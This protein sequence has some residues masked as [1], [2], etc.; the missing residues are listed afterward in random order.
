MPFVPFTDGAKMCFDFTISGVEVS[1]CLHFKGNISPTPA[2][3]D[4]LANEG[5]VR[6]AA[7]VLP[8]QTTA[9]LFKGTTVYDLNTANSPV[10]QDYYVTPVAGSSA[11][12]TS[13]LNVAFVLSYLTGNRGRSYRG[14]SYIPGL[15]ETVADDQNWQAQTVI[16]V[17]NGVGTM[18]NAI[19][20]NS[21]FE[22]VVASRVQNGQLLQ[23]GVM[24]PVLAL[25]GKSD[26][27]TR[28]KRLQGT[29]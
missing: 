5:K 11:T 1:I 24:T 15:S 17:T 12:P 7:N 14:R 18:I 27:G 20:N 22:F 21:P 6:W 8:L 4:T 23:Q 13:P 10:Y 3:Y 19:E 16:D 28:R 25:V 29:F 9:T 26:L 2:D